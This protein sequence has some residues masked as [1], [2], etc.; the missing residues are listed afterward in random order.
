[1]EP[2]NVN[3]VVDKKSNGALVGSIIVVLILVLGGFYLWQ[4]NSMKD[5]N[6]FDEGSMKQSLGNSNQAAVITAMEADIA[7]IQSENSKQDPDVST[8][9]TTVQ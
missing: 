6:E 1:M 7:G 2:N 5:Q 9:V 8:D 3:V 4:S